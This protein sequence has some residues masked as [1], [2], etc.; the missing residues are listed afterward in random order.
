MSQLEILYKYEQGAVQVILRW[1]LQ[2]LQLVVLTCSFPT[3]SWE[4][5]LSAFAIY[6]GYVVTSK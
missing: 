6:L 2:T 3:Y 1:T 5:D 4:L